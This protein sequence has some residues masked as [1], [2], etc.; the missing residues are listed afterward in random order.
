MPP[1]PPGRCCPSALLCPREDCPAL[2]CP[3]ATCPDGRQAPT[4][5]GKCCPDQGLCDRERLCASHDGGCQPE[6]CSNGELAPVPEGSCCPSS[7]LCPLQ[8]CQGIFCP[9]KRCPLTGDLAPIP[10]DSCCPS[11]RQCGNTN[12]SQVRCIVS[13]CPDGS[14]APVPRR[15]CCPSLRACPG[16]QYTVISEEDSPSIPAT[17]TATV[18]EG[19]YIRG[20]DCSMVTCYMARC[21]SSNMVAP[22]PWGN[23]CPNIRL[24]PLDPA[25]LL[26][27]VSPQLVKQSVELF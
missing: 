18:T 23:C 20:T 3:T 21:S 1:V 22:V 17:A 13:R 2:P 12:C 16:A 27:T 15:Q 4:P 14:I 19:S 25:V 9:P 7:A 10:R 26:E 8:H 5:T 11:H 6:Y 24:C